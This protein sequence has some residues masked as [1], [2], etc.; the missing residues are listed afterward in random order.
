MSMSTKVNIYG[1]LYISENLT[2]NYFRSNSNLSDPLVP[3][4]HLIDF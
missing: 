2:G 4:V 1:A 3:V